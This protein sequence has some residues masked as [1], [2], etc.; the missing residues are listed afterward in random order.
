MQPFNNNRSSHVET[1]YNNVEEEEKEYREEP[2][3]E[4]MDPGSAPSEKARRYIDTNAQEAAEG[5]MSPL[6]YEEFAY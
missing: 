5:Q 6:N 2:V 1:N 4:D 3:V